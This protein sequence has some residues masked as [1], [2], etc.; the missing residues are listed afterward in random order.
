MYAR[1]ANAL[2]DKDTI[3]LAGFRKHDWR[4]DIRWNTQAG[5]GGAIRTVTFLNILSDQRVRDALRFMS[6][7]PDE[8]VTNDI[9]R[10]IC[11]R[12]GLKAYLG[13]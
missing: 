11:L 4:P 6:R 2:T 13:N 3:V 1:R 12:Q 7:S 10:E 8:R 9:A 5:I